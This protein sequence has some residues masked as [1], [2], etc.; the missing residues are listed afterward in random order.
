M[1]TAI[2][3]LCQH[4]MDNVTSCGSPAMRGQRY[5]YYHQRKHKRGARKEEERARQT[6]FESV[7]LNNATSV[8]RALREVMKRILCGQI[9]YKKAGQILYK[10]QTASVNLRSA[11]T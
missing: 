7:P 10:L 11:D 4:R 1:G 3:P 9:D 8:Q 6:W 5:C 2:I